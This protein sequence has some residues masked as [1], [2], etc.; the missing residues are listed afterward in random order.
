MTAGSQG[1]EMVSTPAQN[2]N[3]VCFNPGLGAM[4]HIVITLL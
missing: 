4:F 3:N 2:V 1:G